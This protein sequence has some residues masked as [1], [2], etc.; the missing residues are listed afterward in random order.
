MRA[1][2]QTHFGALPSQ[3]IKCAASQNRGATIVLTLRAAV[4][5]AQICERT[6]A[7]LAKCVRRSFARVIAVF[8]E[9]SAT[10]AGA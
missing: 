2:S 6:S 8:R 3:T 10:R 4:Q 7:A 1:S 5:A 9:A